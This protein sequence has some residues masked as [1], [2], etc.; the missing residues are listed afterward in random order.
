MRAAPAASAAGKHPR[1]AEHFR[2]GREPKWGG[3]IAPVTPK[4]ED[5]DP[6]IFLVHHDHNIKANVRTG[7]P[8]QCARSIPHCL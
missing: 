2:S 8:P 7:F 4:Y 6:F 3:F 5:F 1:P